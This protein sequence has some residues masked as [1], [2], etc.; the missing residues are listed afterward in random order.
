MFPRKTNT[1]IKKHPSHSAKIDESHK[2]ELKRI[3]NENLLAGR[4]TPTV[5][6]K[7]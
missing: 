1:A 2:S 6:K 5:K 3:K 4:N 7:I